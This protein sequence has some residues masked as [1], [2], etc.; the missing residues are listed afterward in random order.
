MK[1]EIVLLTIFSAMV[2]LPALSQ[3]NDNSIPPETFRT[4]PASVKCQASV[5]DAQ[6]NQTII[7]EVAIIS[8]LGE[9]PFVSVAS[10]VKNLNFKF[11]RRFAAGNLADDR[12]YCSYSYDSSTGDLSLRYFCSDMGE[13]SWLNNYYSSIRY[14]ANSGSYSQI[15]KVASYGARGMRPQC[16]NLTSCQ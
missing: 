5:S 8:D 7:G 1:F 4:L 2:S 6:G 16:W 9:N 12:D 3:Q 11:G 13:K 15:C 10:T 14:S